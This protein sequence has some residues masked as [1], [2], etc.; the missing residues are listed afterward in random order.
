VRLHESD[1]PNST[2]PFLMQLSKAA[3]VQL[4]SE[5]AG[6]QILAIIESFLVRRAICG[7]EPTGLHA[8][9]KKLWTDCG[10]EFIGNRVTAEIA[11]HKTVVWPNAEEFKNAIQ[12]R[13]LYGSGITPYFIIEYDRSLKGDLPKK[14]PWIEHV[15]PTSPDDGWW[16]YFTKEQHEEMK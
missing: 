8:V 16:K 7:H 13:A 2:L 10:A 12:N 5:D 3:S 1:L 9:F 11:K 15:L 6:E 4:I 14:A